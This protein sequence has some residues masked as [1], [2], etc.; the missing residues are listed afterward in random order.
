MQTIT[1]ANL[2]D[3]LRAYLD[4]VARGEELV[5]ESNHRPFARMLPLA[6]PNEM[7][8]DDTA[9]VAAGLMRLPSAELTEEFW[10]TPAPQVSTEAIVT[11]IQA[12]R[13]ER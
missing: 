11:A 4:Q 10:Q 7:E 6:A 9:L 12:D 8:A 3:N 2:Q 5:I 13:D 1:V